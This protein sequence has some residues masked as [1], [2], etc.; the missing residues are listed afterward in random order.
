MLITGYKLLWDSKIQF[1]KIFTLYKKKHALF[2]T[3]ER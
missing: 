1:Q 3:A 2:Y